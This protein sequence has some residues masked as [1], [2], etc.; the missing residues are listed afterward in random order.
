VV[1]NYDRCLQYFMYHAAQAYYRLDQ[2]RAGTLINGIHFYH[3]Y[4]S[5]G[6]LPWQRKNEDVVDYGG[7]VTAGQLLALS[8]RIKTF[9]EST[10][11]NVIDPIRRAVNAAQRIVFLG[12]AYHDQNVRLLWPDTMTVTSS[13][14][15]YFGTAHGISESDV[16]ILL[17]E[18]SARTGIDY[19][20]LP[21]IKCAQLFYEY[22]Q[23]LSMR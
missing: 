5:V 13:E 8:N 2:D 10:A 21:R 23:S 12:F 3:P 16:D 18:I 14:K 20:R 1:F 22:K 4:G 11:E 17:K 9:T 15:R 6:W 19:G 7:E